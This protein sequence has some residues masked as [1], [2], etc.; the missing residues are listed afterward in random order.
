M[1][2]QTAFLWA[3][4]LA[5]FLFVAQTTVAEDLAVHQI[6]ALESAGIPLYPG[7]TYTTGDDEIATIMWFSSTDSPDSI[8]DWYEDKLS[9]WSE[10]ESNGSRV[11]YKGPAG[12]TATD[13]ST[14]PYLWARTTDE[15]GVSTDTEITI[16]IPK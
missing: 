12:M 10:L 6:N 16:W 2:K 3:L 9:D 14:I 13:L 8:M 11:I 7:S 4:P 5:L 1:K 15:S